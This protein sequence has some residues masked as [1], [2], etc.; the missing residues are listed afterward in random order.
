MEL[1][2]Q[3][4]ILNH[5][6][7]NLEEAEKG[8]LELI[9]DNPDDEKLNFLLGTLYL[10]GGKP[11]VSSVFLGKSI[12]KNPTDVK[13]INN[14]GLAYQSMG[15]YKDA[16]KLFISALKID[17]NYLS[18]YTNLGICYQLEGDYEK[19]VEALRTSL[20]IN[21]NDSE[22]LYNLGAVLH[23]QGNSAEALENY[24]KAVEINPNY[25]EALYNIALIYIDKKEYENAKNNLEKAFNILPDNFDV[26]FNL[27][28]VNEQLND[29]ESAEKLYNSA[30]TLKPNSH[31]LNFNLANIYKA[32]KKWEKAEVLYKEAYDSELKAKV[33]NNLGFV[34]HKQGK[35]EEAAQNY[36]TALVLDNDYHDAKLNLGASL[37]E[38]GEIED[39]VRKYDEILKND[40]SNSAA[41]FNKAVA[42]LLLGNFEEG[43]K[44][45][46]WRFY[47]GNVQK[48]QF[49]KPVW[50]G[51]KL[52]GK[53]ILVHDEQ[54]IG[55]SIQFVR[56][57]KLLKDNGAFIIFKCRPV[58]SELYK[59]LDFVDELLE[60]S[61]KCESDY[62]FEISLMSLPYAFNTNIENIPDIGKYLNSDKNRRDI[63]KDKLANDEKL[64]VGLVWK[65]NPKNEF[66]FKRSMDLKVLD[67]ILNN[68]NILFYS[69]QKENL[70]GE[71]ENTGVID[72][73]EL[74]STLEDTA[75]VVSE[76]D[77]II[78]VDTAM[79][80]LAGALGKE[81]WLLL[82]NIPDWRWML[83]KDSSPWYPSVKLFRQTEHGNWN[84]VISDLKIELNRRFIERDDSLAKEFIN[85][86]IE[87]FQFHV[88]GELEKAER[89]YLELLNV[90][91]DD[92]ELCFWLASLY[93]SQN[94]LS[95]AVKYFEYA[96]LIKPD[97]TEASELLASL[98]ENTEDYIKAAAL[99]EKQL[100]GNEGEF[101]LLFKLGELY[102]R[103][104][105]LD[106]S[107]KY[108]S[109][110]YK[111]DQN[112]FD[113][114]NIYGIVLQ[115]NNKLI[116]SR[117]I[118]KMA[119]EISPLTPGVYLNLGNSY[120]LEQK[121]EDAL[122]NYNEAV[123]LNPDYKDAHIAKGITLL[124]NEN[125][126]QG[127]KEYI[128]GLKK[129]EGI[130]KNNTVS[131]WKPVSGN[132]ETVIVYSEQGAGDVI[133][134]SRYLALIKEL[135]YRI[136]FECSESLA[137]LFKNSTYIDEIIVS[138]KTDY[139]SLNYDFYVPLLGLPGIFNTNSK[140][141]P[142][143][144]DL[145]KVDGIG[146][147]LEF[148]KNK[149]N[150]GFIWAGNPK[151]GNDHI[152][153]T[154]LEYFESLFLNENL[155][156]YS[157]QKEAGREI[158]VICGKY[159]NVHNLSDK[160][161]SFLTTAKIINQ[162]D[163]VITVE[164]GVAHLAGTLGKKTWTILPYMP[165]WRWLLERNDSP[166]YPSMKLFRQQE[167]GDWNS[168]FKKL[169]NEITS[170]I[171]NKADDQ[172]YRENIEDHVEEQKK[173]A[174]LLLDENKVEA[175]KQVFQNVLQYKKSPGVY[176]DLGY[177]NHLQNNLPA[178]LE[179][180]N[181]TL[182]LDPSDF[183]ALNNIGII[184]KDLMCLEDAANSLLL[185]LKIKHDNPVALNN[186][187][188][189]FDLR[190]DFK[191]AIELFGNAVKINPNY[192]E[193]YMNAA[194]SYDTMGLSNEALLFINKAIEINPDNVDA[195]F[196]KSLIL[197][198]NKNFSEGLK[199]YEWRLH[200]KE[201][202]S[203]NYGKPV[204]NS[205]E[206]K[207]KKVLVFDEQGYGDTLNFGRYINELNK[208]GADVDLECH[209]ALKNL[210]NNCTGVNNVYERGSLD[211]SEIHHDY[212]VPLLSLPNFFGTE[213]S[214][215]PSQVPYLDVNDKAYQYWRGWFSEIDKPK[216]GI[217]WEG[218]KP[219]N[220]LHRASSLK[221]FSV[222]T[223]LRDI[224]FVSL[225]IGDAA[226]ENTGMMK[227]YNIIDLS[228]EIKDFEDTAAVIKNLDLVISVDT[229]VAHLAGALG[230]KVWTLLSYKADWRWFKDTEVSPWYPTMKLFRQRKF[231]DWQE[232]LLR[233]KIQLQKELTH[234]LD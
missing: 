182:E 171:Y 88:K 156:F 131:I 73:S 127:W 84:N 133:Q 124:I 31:E 11:D 204:L 17:K 189:I 110:A 54:G 108:L 196:N 118:L 67:G 21:E 138:G 168:I 151:N 232:L 93:K 125:Y 174:R 191:T 206:L 160:L 65:G 199:E 123:K 23:N 49:S 147:K 45:Y 89:L 217:V 76:M 113:L 208:L 90:F 142:A 126:E 10:Q 36:S 5:Q 223:E 104:N 184:L 169:E 39:A 72:I 87:A 188:I 179:C 41:H 14:L 58:L 59:Q 81:T 153:S 77:L 230:K 107:Q 120:L 114:L 52:E 157:L 187:G 70:T 115:K 105:N 116:E 29:L 164:T 6:N 82:S 221:H 62:D 162:L 68:E 213:Y 149:I 152:R 20:T 12:S 46:E 33:Y 227:D 176:F 18:A 96:L 63:I 95:N 134:F 79:A 201:Y 163:L 71:L 112:N 172:L 97:Y 109:E 111:L 78:T 64:K 8:Y 165:D 167:P 143:C 231:N 150:I 144:D 83:K 103:L 51:E 69:L 74:V 129:P 25:I 132:G 9:K 190:G 202:R 175:A 3:Q 38:L 117:E 4:S 216:I 32:Q 42:L 24:E 86:K 28:F 53:T 222:L 154:K 44:E 140:N 37:L 15:K 203:N 130:T 148:D 48:P 210:M 234:I 197:L 40:P 207:G 135:D 194:N 119:A 214:S 30:K 122:R 26:L 233:I 106:K 198:K 61:E 193:A 159:K 218:K 220:N 181:K 101:N 27:G 195:H 19:A 177:C 185:S 56:Y 192:A 60:L 211:L 212:Q 99:Y 47:E 34:Q 1:E 55:D 224:Q 16:I 66:D 141:I 57:L 121:F 226:R 80:H 136:I 22:T 146:D 155:E 180:Y 215:I 161:D 200:K 94:D 209:S 102:G 50:N 229:S 85:K 228:G 128:W 75:A 2:L 219:L 137:G 170:L 7:G 183:N 205:K 145:I 98:Y 158:D 173:Y 91:N 178:A 166:W 35:F 13:A 43:W 92:A 100:A 225:Q 186:L 139:A